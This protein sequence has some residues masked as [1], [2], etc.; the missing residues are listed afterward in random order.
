MEN[1]EILLEP[2]DFEHALRDFKSLI[3]EYDKAYRKIIDSNSK[4]SAA[5]KGEAGSKFKMQSAI[6]ENVFAKNL[7]S[8]EIILQSRLQYAL[9]N[10]TAED[11]KWAKSFN[12]NL[13][14]PK[15]ESRRMVDVK[16]GKVEKSKTEIM[17][18]LNGLVIK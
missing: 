10:I 8:L 7:E 3:D 9:D 16:S 14:E 13:F 5:W 12:V 1:Q 15:V 11:L 6:I 2:S 18:D 4:L 17:V